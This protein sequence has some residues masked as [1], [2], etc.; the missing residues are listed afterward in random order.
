MAVVFKKNALNPALNKPYMF[1]GLVAATRALTKG[2]I[3]ERTETVNA[4]A[5]AGWRPLD[6]DFDMSDQ[7]NSQGLAIAT[8]DKTTS[9]RV[10]YYWFIAPRE[11]DVFEVPLVGAAAVIEQGASL[12]YD[13]TNDT[14]GNLQSTGTNA[15]A[16][17]EGQAQYP[18]PQKLLSAGQ[19]GDEGTTIRASETVLV[20]FRRSCS[21]LERIV[22]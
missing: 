7:A 2:D 21:H 9:D 15:I 5:N 19:L 6:S 14:A 1:R 4:V 10:G 12:Y 17:V 13:D 3:C 8:V 11:G 16:R 22:N 20:C 18:R